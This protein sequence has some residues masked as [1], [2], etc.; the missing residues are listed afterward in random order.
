MMADFDATAS[1]TV[2]LPSMLLFKKKFLDAIRN[3]GKTQ[4]VRL[5]KRPMLRAGQASYIP[6][7]G[8]IRITAVD[9]V[10]L[11]DLTDD[12]A[13]PDGFETADALRREINHLYPPPWPDGL[14][15]YRVKFRRM[16]EQ[17]VAEH[18]ANR[19]PRPKKS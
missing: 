4:T 3:G 18:K 14:A 9:R 5:W 10:E 13:L 11:A 15:A 12:D 16:S 17:E 7:A 1:A 19:K 2:S 8:Y 6:G